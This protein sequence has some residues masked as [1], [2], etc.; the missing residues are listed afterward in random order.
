MTFLLHAWRNIWRNGK[1]TAITVVAVTLTTAVLIVTLSLMRGFGDDMVHNATRL[2]V[3]DA[4]VHEADYRLDRSIYKSIAN[5]EAIVQ[6]AQKAGIDAAPRSYSFGLV[7]SGHKSAG[8]MFWGV[9]PAAEKTAFELAKEMFAGSYLSDR[10]DREVVLGRK[11]AKSL[12]AQV[13]AEIVAV[14]QAAD[15]S[16][17][18]ELFQ[19]IGILKLAGEEI[20]RGAAIIHR[21]DFDSLFVSGGRVHEIA[22]NAWDRMSP[23]QVVAKVS[24]ALSEAS[25]A[26]TWR[27]LMPQLASMVDM[28]D[29]ALAIFGFIFFLAAGLGVMNTMLMATYERIRE[30]G[31]LKAIGASPWRILRDISTEAFV[32]SVISTSLG[33]IIG[34]AAS[35]YLE[36]HPIDLSVF[37][38]GDMSISGMVFNPLWRA[39]V[40]QQT[41]VV[42]VV[43]MWIVCVLA[44]L[45]PA[46]K[47]ARLDPIRA[48]N[49][50]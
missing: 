39:T 37:G 30:F 24:S 5:P 19:V 9:S 41:V 10:A 7:S 23:E 12:H 15:G 47:A 3:G 28:M 14:V 45:Y 34:V 27:E 13:G 35:L 8:A 44:S 40:D 25:V 2:V 29:A 48:I 4:Q 50:V 11:L 26:Q 36:T 22:L 17:G 6:A 31:I 20:D 38:S 16:L 43:V 18:N 32:M 33:A 46:T 1:R 49:H 21:Q 42:P